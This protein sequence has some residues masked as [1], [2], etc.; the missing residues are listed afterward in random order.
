MQEVQ[1][2][3]QYLVDGDEEINRVIAMVN[4]QVEVVEEEKR[5]KNMEAILKNWGIGK[6]MW[7]SEMKIKEQIDRIKPLSDLKLI[8]N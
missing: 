1:S 8:F 5:V 2:G 6:G 4:G 7:M 3:A